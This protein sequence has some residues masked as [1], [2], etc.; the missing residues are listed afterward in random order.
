VERVRITFAEI[1]RFVEYPFAVRRHFFAGYMSA[2][3]RQCRENGVVG[4]VFVHFVEIF[5]KTFVEKSVLNSLFL[6]A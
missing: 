3:G 2:D 5:E 4:I 6:G 1:A